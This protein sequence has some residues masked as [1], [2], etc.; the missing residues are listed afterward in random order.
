MKVA[1]S[2]PDCVIGIFH[3]HNPSGPEVDSD[4]EY[5][6]GGGGGEVNAAGA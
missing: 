6:P 3:W 4:Q 5:F 1:S 2:I